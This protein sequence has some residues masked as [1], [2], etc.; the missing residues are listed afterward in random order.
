M[1]RYVELIPPG[2]HYFYFVKNNCYYFVNY[3]V[4]GYS[5]LLTSRLWDSEILVY[6]WIRLLYQK[7]KRLIS[8]NICYQEKGRL[9]RVFTLRREEVCLSIGLRIR[10]RC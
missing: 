5:Y 9:S 10:K 4:N 2:K 3:K 1:L 7:I 6:I 8:I